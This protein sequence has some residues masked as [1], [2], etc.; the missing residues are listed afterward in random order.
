VLAVTIKTEQVSPLDHN[1]FFSGGQS[2]A[3]D[4]N[5]NPHYVY[6]G[7]GLYHKWFDGNQW[8]YET[9]DK[10]GMNEANIVSDQNGKF[11][12]LYKDKT[13]H[14]LKYATNVSGNWVTEDVNG[15]RD[16]IGSTFIVIDRTGKPCITF[17]DYESDEFIFGCRTLGVWSETVVETGKTTGHGNSVTFDANNHPYIAY[18]DYNEGMKYATRQSSGDWTVSLIDGNY[19]GKTNISLDSQDTLHIAY[20]AKNGTDYTLKIA[21]STSAGGWTFDVVPT[22]NAR[23]PSS[24]VSMAIDTNDHIHI[25]YYDKDARE[26]LYRN[27]SNGTWS[28]E[29]IEDNISSITGDDVYN[30]M[31][32]DDNNKAFLAYMC[33]GGKLYYATNSGAD[34]QNGLIDTSRWFI[35]AKLRRGPQ[36]K[37]YAIYAD[38]QNS[39]LF[40]AEKHGNVWQSERLTSNWG[41]G[42]DM[43]IDKNGKA[44]ICWNE[45]GKLMYTA[46]VSGDWTIEQVDNTYNNNTSISIDVDSQNLPHISYL[47]N[48]KKLR[49]AFK[50]SGVW[51]ATTLDDS[52][53]DFG[54]ESMVIDSHDKIHIA[55]TDMANDK[56]KYI[57]NV[58]GTWDDESIADGI[59]D[60]YV[61]LALDGRNHA[62]ISYITNYKITY[63]NN[64]VGA[65]S[66]PVIPTFGRNSSWQFGLDGGGTVHYISFGSPGNTVVHASNRGGDWQRTLLG[67]NPDSSY[68]TSANRL[69]IETPYKMFYIYSNFENKNIYYDEVNLPVDFL[70]PVIMYLLH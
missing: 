11:H 63:I 38:I 18:S 10:N 12:I 17:K 60:S 58:S 51:A 34:W 57:S 19:T 28:S 56:L 41:S 54:G 44:H 3:L 30:S 9:I 50:T 16:G 26:L 1:F 25:S 32:L 37:L 14:I 69:Q 49:Y 2:V 66:S 55:Y 20:L 35:G 70:P 64:I 29:L 53:T 61:V 42:H 59:T 6:A 23:I 47:G 27:N 39:S 45:D 62:H 21:S 43:A 40:Y 52:S 15:Q 24:S 68:E 7:N 13:K 31:I 46:N 5:G 67:N 33:N 65:W 22:S 8:Q 48:Y 36:G 4:T